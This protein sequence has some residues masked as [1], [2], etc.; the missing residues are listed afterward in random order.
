MSSSLVVFSVKA[1]NADPA[2]E[3]L[4]IGWCYIVGWV[5]VIFNVATFL[6]GFCADKL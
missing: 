2:T 3:D 5:G 1:P 6:F 4:E